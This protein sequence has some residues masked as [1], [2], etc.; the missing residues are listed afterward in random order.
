MVEY[1]MHFAFK[2]DMIFM[3]Q[4][5]WRIPKQSH[6]DVLQKIRCI[7]FSDSLKMQQ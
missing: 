2:C 4:F 7:E 3:W 5:F 6:S 1:C